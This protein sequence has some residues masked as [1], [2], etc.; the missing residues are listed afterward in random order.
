MGLAAVIIAGLAVLVSVVALVLGEA[1]A[2]KRSG[3]DDAAESRARKADQR[4][5]ERAQRERIELRSSQLGQPTTDLVG[6]EPGPERAYRFRVTNIGGSS[7]SHL[8][9]ELVDSSGEVC[10]QPPSDTVLGA[11]QAG[12]RAEFVLKVTRPFNRNPLFLHYTW[13]DKT[14]LQERL[15]NVNVP[16][17]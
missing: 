8:S 16:T 13:Y 4:D 12:E 1:R 7:I 5:E 3:L 15:S 11:L 17:A 9:P 6:R 10:S 14:G 2:R